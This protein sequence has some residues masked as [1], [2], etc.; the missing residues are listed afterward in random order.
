MVCITCNLPSVVY[1]LLSCLNLPP[2]TKKVPQ[3]RGVRDSEPSHSGDG[4]WVLRVLEDVAF[5]E[6]HRGILLQVYIVFFFSFICLTDP[7]ELRLL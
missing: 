4:K 3:P 1:N 7:L 2:V 6:Q 5:S